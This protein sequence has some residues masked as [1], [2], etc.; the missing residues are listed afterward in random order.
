MLFAK[1]KVEVAIEDFP[2]SGFSFSNSML[3]GV[4]DKIIGNGFL[5]DLSLVDFLIEIADDGD[6]KDARDDTKL[7]QVI[8][9]MTRMGKIERVM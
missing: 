4:L 8:A 5:K 1:L 2:S 9:M 3:D 6:G 7:Q